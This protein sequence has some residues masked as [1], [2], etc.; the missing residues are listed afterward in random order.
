MSVSVLI[1]DDHAGFR[2]LARKV[3]GADDY[4]VVGEASDGASAIAALGVLKPELVLLDIQLPD[5]DG[6]DVSQ[7]LIKESP[8]LKIV[9]ISSR[10]AR[11]YGCRLD[12]SD[13][14]G[15]IPKAELCATALTKVLATAR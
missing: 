15:F 9:L 3:L 11:D 8:E 1:V 10:D 6:F 12:Q 4:V 7:Q 2:S 5:R 13:V 14:R